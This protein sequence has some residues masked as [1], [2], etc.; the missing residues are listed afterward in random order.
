MEEQILELINTQ[1]KLS[2]EEIKKYAKLY[3]TSIKNIK[4]T[5]EKIANEGKIYY[6]N[7]E[8]LYYKIGDIYK[9]V[10]ILSGSD[11]KKYFIDEHNKRRDILDENLNG[12]LTFSKVI[13]QNDGNSFKVVKVI[14]HKY[15][16]IVCEVVNNYD[17]KMLIPLNLPNN[18]LIH[19]N[20]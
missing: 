11:S 10:E 5:L 15:D 2:I 7:D 16:K 9:V 13:V 6:N 12:A 19:V 18:Y 14:E 8:D 1:E 20:K 3:T 4:K 17:E